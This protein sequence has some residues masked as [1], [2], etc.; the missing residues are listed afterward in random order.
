MAKRPDRRRGV[1]GNYGRDYSDA[2]MEFFTAMEKYKE[3]YKM[4]F[5]AKSDFFYVMTVILG[6]KKPH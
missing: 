3:K 5:P 2:E 4:P 6:Y 1:H